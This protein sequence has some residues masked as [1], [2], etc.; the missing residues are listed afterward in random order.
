MSLETDYSDWAKIP[1]PLQ[2]QFFSHARDEALAC[3]K[4]LIEQSEKLERLRAFLNFRKIPEDDQWKNWR[5]ASVDGSYSPTISERLG[6][7]YGVYC[8]GYMIFEG[9]EVV[10]EGYRSGK[11]SQ[12]QVTDPMLTRQVLRLLCTELERE[13][14]VHCLENEGVDLLLIDGSFFGFRARMQQIRNNEV[15]LEGLKTV[16]ELVDRVRDAS[17]QL[18]DSKKAVGIVKRTITTAFDGWLT[19]KNGNEGACI[20][21]NDRAILASLMPQN[22]WFAYDWLLGSP[23]AFLFFTRFMNYY[24]SARSRIGTISMESALSRSEREAREAIRRNLNCEAE[25]ILPIS[26]YYVRCAEATPPFC[27]E[28]HQ[29]VDTAPLLAYFKANCNPATGLPF[30]IDLIDEGVSLPRKFTKEF[31]EEVEALLIRDEELD[32]IDLSNYFAYLNPQ[33]EE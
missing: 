3:K 15:N 25:S 5:I 33:K 31:V 12:E 6:A 26:R 7:S 8:G 32:K 17:I 1:V 19:Y 18:M 11:L 27:F 14:A 21:R 29:N 4:R 16:G 9:G 30:P 13:I 28:T 24:R 20:G 10:K 2:H 23:S 22:H